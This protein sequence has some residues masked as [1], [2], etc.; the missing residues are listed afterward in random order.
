MPPKKDNLNYKNA[1]LIRTYTPRWL[2]CEYMCSNIWKSLYFYNRLKQ[3]KAK[4]TFYHNSG[5]HLTGSARR[6]VPPSTLKQRFLVS[7]INTTVNRI[8]LNSN[9]WVETTNKYSTV[10]K[11]LQTS[12]FAVDNKTVSIGEVK[13]STLHRLPTFCVSPYGPSTVYTSRVMWPQLQL[14]FL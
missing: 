9:Y 8:R 4:D 1:M 11:L 6:G 5:L 10:V 13:D 7:R 12:I 14:H 2:S 3:V